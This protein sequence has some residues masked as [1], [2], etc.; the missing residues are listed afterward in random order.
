LAQIL[1]LDV[2]TVSLSL[3]HICSQLDLDLARFTL[4]VLHF[5]IYIFLLD[6]DF[7]FG[8]GFGFGFSFGF[9][10]DLAHLQAQEGHTEVVE[11][12]LK[13][14]ADPEVRVIR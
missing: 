1:L 3:I 7:G 11:Y 6:F 13:K 4:Q 14:G 5:L 9:G 10:F 8:I 2:G 12:L